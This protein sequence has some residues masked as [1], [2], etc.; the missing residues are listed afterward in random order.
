LTLQEDLAQILVPHNYNTWGEK[1]NP[2][3]RGLRIQPTSLDRDRRFFGREVA[4]RRVVS[5][6]VGKISA[7]AFGVPSPCWVIK[8]LADW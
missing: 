4:V 2:D 1:Q 3:I 5:D 7:K 6:G 8:R